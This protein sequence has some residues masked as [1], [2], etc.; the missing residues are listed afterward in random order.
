[1]IPGIGHLDYPNRLRRLKLPTLAYRRL[2]GDMITV[3]KLT[4]N[5]EFSFDNTLPELLTR[6]FTNLRGHNKKLFLPKFSKDIRKY[7]F[8]CR[9][10]QNWNNLPY[11]VVNAKTIKEF[12]IRLDKF[13]EN[14]QVLYDDF[15]SSIV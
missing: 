3:F 14:Q 2:R 5:E 1:M 4:S 12:E 13:W 6:S 8:N 9:T 10:V 11:E 7:S 15:K